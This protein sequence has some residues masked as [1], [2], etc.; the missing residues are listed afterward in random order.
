MI[1]CCH[2]G[3]NPQP[4][5]ESLFSVLIK[6]FHLDNWIL[7]DCLMCNDVRMF[8]I[9]WQIQP[10]PIKYRVLCLCIIMCDSPRMTV[11]TRNLW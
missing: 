2:W 9:S 6:T 10:R 1:Y 7:L 11:H 5:V 3:L 8:A 4:H